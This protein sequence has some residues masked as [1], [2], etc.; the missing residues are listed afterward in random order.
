MGKGLG[1][2]CVLPGREAFLPVPLLESFRAVQIPLLPSTAA[3][4]QN[5]K[6]NGN[7]RALSENK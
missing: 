4:K 6:K 1:D 7:E 5:G 3:L 2:P